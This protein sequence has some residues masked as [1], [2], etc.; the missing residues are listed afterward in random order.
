MELTRRGRKRAHHKKVKTGCTTCKIRKVRC[1]EAKPACNRCLSTGRKCDGYL[2]AADAC[3]VSST[4]LR[5]YNPSAESRLALPP[6]SLNEIRS[7]QFFINV[8]ARSI[9][10]T[11]DAEFWRT[12]IPRIC[13]SDP[14]IWHA[15]VSFGSVHESYI[16]AK[17]TT[18]TKNMF[19]MQQFNASI[20]CLTDPESSNYTNKWR[21]MV[22]STI[23]TCVCHLEGLEEQAR[24]HLR[25]GCRLLREIEYEETKAKLNEHWQPQGNADHVKVQT[26][27]STMAP[28]SFSSISSILTGFQIR[29]QALNRG[30]ILEFPTLISHHDSF[31]VWRYYTAPY[32]RPYLTARNLRQ[33]N[34]AIE[35]LMNSTIFFMQ[36]YAEKIKDL[37]TGKGGAEL[38]ESLSQKQEPEVRCFREISKA[39]RSFETELVTV[40]GVRLNDTAKRPLKIGLL[41]LNLYH[42][43]IRFILLKDPEEPDTMKR[44]ALLPQMET[45]IIK[46]AGQI[47]DLIEGDGSGT[48]SFDPIPPTSG[49]LF[50]VAHSGFTQ[51][52]RRQAVRLLK[53]PQMIGLWDSG[54]S[55]KLA[56]AIM[57]REETVAYE[58][59][60]RKV[61][62][63]E[64]VPETRRD[65]DILVQPLYRIF[66]ITMSIT[67]RREAT[68]VMRTWQEW[69]HGKSGQRSVVNW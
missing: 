26:S 14:A 29:A 64:A 50:I 60:L 37:L 46:L 13:Q 52:T 63:G 47:L 49:P 4:A 56:E 39:I 59:R 3:T 12:E 27:T 8:T 6:K 65:E 66:S 28:I 51:E 53:R 69:M 61:V 54:L 38:L 33:A 35:S 22:V 44:Y 40:E 21:A 57:A 67:G 62:E 16:T 31:S 17:P 32:T 25:A 24:I 48:H 34:R 15:I 9:A 18:Y 58:D 2:T 68:I 7:Y 11:F 5:P 43:T 20:R 42:K 1:D 41:T 45:S 10:T 55:A 30:G 23:F 19:A 36:K